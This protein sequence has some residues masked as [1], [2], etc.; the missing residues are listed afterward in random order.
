MTDAEHFDVLIAGQGAAAYAAALYAARYRVKTLVAGERFGGETA[1]GGTIEN[2]P[3]HPEIDGFDLMLRFQEQVTRYDVPIRNADVTTLATDGDH[4]MATLSDD[5]HVDASAVILAIGR[6]RRMLG[7]PNEAEWTGRGVSYCSTCDAPLYRDKVAAVVGG[8]SAAV[9]G[10][11]LNAR[12]AART[13]LIY[14]GDRLWRP[15]PVLV[16]LLG[17]TENVDVLLETEVAE[18]LGSDD[19]GLTGVRLDRAHDGSDTLDLDVLFI[20]A[21]ADPRVDLARALG[22]ELN[23]ETDEVHVDREMRTNV[24]GLFAAGDL[25][26][27]SGALKQTVTA[28]AQGAIAALSAYQY[29]TEHG[30]YCQWHQSGFVL[31]G[32]AELAAR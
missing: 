7:L 2:Y 19:A 14:R 29:V 28:A 17:Q 27:G 24:P 18:L 22:V 16:E 1:I 12:H 9:E 8:G 26:D 30:R 3:G 31:E 11:L 20:E 6:E 23:P 21:G 10:A 5:T 13:Y 15:E 32:E 4:F 25:T